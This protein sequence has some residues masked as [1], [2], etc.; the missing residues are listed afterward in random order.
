MRVIWHSA[1]YISDGGLGFDS[2]KPYAQSPCVGQMLSAGFVL[3]MAMRI[4]CIERGDKSA[5]H[6]DSLVVLSFKFDTLEH[7]NLVGVLDHDLE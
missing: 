4:N 6:C 1:V 3:G 2:R 5:P 7:T